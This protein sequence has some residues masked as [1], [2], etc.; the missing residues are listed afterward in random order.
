MRP[1]PRLARR[2]N[3]SSLRL[4]PSVTLDDLFRQLNSV[5]S[6]LL[7]RGCERILL[8]AAAR[9]GSALPAQ[10]AA[11]AAVAEKSPL[12]RSSVTP[13]VSSGTER[14]SKRGGGGGGF[15]GWF[16][17]SRHS[18]LNRSFTQGGGGGGGGGFTP[19]GAI[20]E[21]AKDGPMYRLGVEVKSARGL[22]ESAGIMVNYEYVPARIEGNHSAYVASGAIHAAPAVWQLAEE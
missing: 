16:S 20:S 11:G 19:L 8:P 10:V 2:Y 3:C 13:S 12:T 1:S 21:D 22:R 17:S 18:S 14:E 7:G 4:W 6:R 15:S 5:K 9:R